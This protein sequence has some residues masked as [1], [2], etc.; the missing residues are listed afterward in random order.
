MPFTFKLSQRLARMY[1]LG[2]SSSA[3]GRLCYPW[4]VPASRRTSSFHPMPSV[5][6]PAEHTMRH[7]VSPQVGDRCGKPIK[8]RSP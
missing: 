4:P 7:A 6:L 3:A 1:D 5:C 2:L 8:E